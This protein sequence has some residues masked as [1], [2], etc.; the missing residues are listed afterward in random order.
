MRIEGRVE[1]L[2][3]KESENYFHS[4]P[5]PSQIGALV[6]CNQSSPIANREVNEFKLRSHANHK[7]KTELFVLLTSNELHVHVVGYAL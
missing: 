6:S 1:K 2:P 4:R 3:E 7:L 5:R